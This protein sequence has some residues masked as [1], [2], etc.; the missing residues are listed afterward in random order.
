LY[1]VDRI[2]GKRELQPRY[3]EYHVVWVGYPDEKDYTWEPSWQLK[4]DVPKA[5]KAYN[6]VQQIIRKREREREQ[7]RAR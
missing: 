5:V 6:R 2:V 7:E 3:I 1:K 4:A